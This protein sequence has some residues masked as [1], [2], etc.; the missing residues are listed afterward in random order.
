ME[1]KESIVIYVTPNYESTKIEE[2]QKFGYEL[3]KR[4]DIHAIF[5]R[6]MAFDIRYLEPIDGSSYVVN[7]I[8]SKYV[9]LHFTRSL[10]FPNLDKIKQI[11]LEYNNLSFPSGP[12]LAVP[13]IFT[14]FIA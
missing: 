2:M 12:S 9:K 5:N 10:G 11:E 8:T 14:F 13:K 3:Q 1:E 6:G 4:Q 7:Q